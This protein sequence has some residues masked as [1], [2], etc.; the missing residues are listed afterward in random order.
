MNNSKFS[1]AILD[2]KKKVG[3][4]LPFFITS[5]IRAVLR[6]QICLTI[7]GSSQHKFCEPNLTAKHLTN[8][9]EIFR[10]FVLNK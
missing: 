2:A 1:H 8:S 10:P 3:C 7:W 4:I 6:E 9:L 5:V